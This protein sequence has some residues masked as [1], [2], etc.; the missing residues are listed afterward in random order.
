[1]AQTMIRWLGPDD[2]FPP[3]DS[4]LTEPNGLLAAGGGLSP[5]RLLDAYVHGIFPWSAE[6]EPVL[7]WSPN[8]RMVLFLEEFH[9]SRTLR[10]RLRRGDFRITADIAFV[11]VMRGCAQP[12]PDAEGT[13]I[14]RDMI[15]AYTEL[16]RRGYAHSIEAWER[17]E[18]AGG[19]YGVAI[20]RMFYG[21]SMFSRRRD[22]SKA[23]FAHLVR[24]LQ[25]WGFGMIDCQMSTPH[26]STLGAREIPRHDFLSRM[27][28]LAVGPSVSGPWRL[29]EDLRET[30]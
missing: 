21:E 13:W 23:A 30:F 15:A 25:R 22:A 19:L 3:V 20:G 28:A 6:D 1:M 9:V 29:D 10:R 17:D 8:P 26:L 18:L 14:T 7:W 12:R 2:P 5:E 27:R 16:W 4:A 24:Q 11:D